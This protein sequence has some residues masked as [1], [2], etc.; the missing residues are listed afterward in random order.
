MKCLLCKKL[1]FLHICTA[2]Q[3]LFLSPKIIRKRVTKNIEVLSFYD[4]K[5]I[6]ELLYTK[7]SDIGAHI[8]TILA[9]N[10]FKKFAENF[11]FSHPVAAIAIDDRPKWGYAHT[12]ILARALHSQ[13]IRYQPARLHA[14][15][16]IAY[17]GRSKAFR[18]N[19]PRNFR[20]KAFPYC[21]LILVDDIITTGTTLHEAI[22]TL[23]TFGKETLL[24]LTLAS[25]GA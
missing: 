6:K 20:Y 7:H 22:T 5:E 18:K 11:S 19:N 9:K 15:N 8:Y 4:Y 12:A 3:E 17:S 23:E 13:F 14:T 16:D 21:D 24:C 10:S 2:C 1:S 25:A